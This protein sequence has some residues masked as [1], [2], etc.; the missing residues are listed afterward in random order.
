MQLSYPGIA[1]QWHTTQNIHPKTGALV[2][3]SEVAPHSRYKAW[4][5]C[6]QE[7]CECPHVWQASIHARCGKQQT[8]CPFC[9]GLQACPCQSL[10]FLRPDIALEWDYEKNAG[11]KT[12]IGTQLTPETCPQFSH[13][14]VNW[15]HVTYDGEN[16]SW[17]AKVKN[18]TS[19]EN[20]CPWCAAT[21]SDRRETSLA[22]DCPKLALEWHPTKNGELRPEDVTRGSHKSVWWLCRTYCSCEGYLDSKPD[23]CPSI[24]RYHD[25]SWEACINDRVRGSGCPFCHGQLEPGK[26]GHAGHNYV[27]REPLEFKC[28]C[29][30]IMRSRN[31]SLRRNPTKPFVEGEILYVRHKNFRRCTNADCKML[32]SA[33]S[34]ETSSLWVRSDFYPNAFRDYVK[35]GRHVFPEK[36]PKCTEIHRSARQSPIASTGRRLIDVPGPYRDAYLARFGDVTGS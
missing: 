12:N 20:G 3:P 9:S 36:C 28:R 29:G 1:K 34:W 14:Q 19:N 30:L 8:G 31:D 23:H 16:H 32:Y 10:A 11:L 17:S 27:A 5:V 24:R 4:W 15:R 25:H 2:C 33:I 18:R 13:V 26:F 6:D 35:Y 7:K 21:I 22:V